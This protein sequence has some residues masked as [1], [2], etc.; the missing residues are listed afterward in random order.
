MVFPRRYVFVVHRDVFVVLYQGDL[1]L[2]FRHNPLLAWALHVR[3]DAARSRLGGLASR[4]L[5][6]V[7]AVGRSKERLRSGFVAFVSDSCDLSGNCFDPSR[8]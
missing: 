8:R 6:A 4:S 1:Q 7:V 5:R 2:C 3:A